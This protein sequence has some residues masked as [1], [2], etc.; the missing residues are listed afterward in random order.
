MSFPSPPGLR[1][2]DARG[3][4]AAAEDDVVVRPGGGNEPTT[5]DKVRA[6]AASELASTLFFLREDLEDALS[7]ATIAVDSSAHSETRALHAHAMAQKGVIEALMGHPDALAT[8]RAADELKVT[9]QPFADGLG[10]QLT[11]RG[12]LLAEHAEVGPASA[13]LALDESGVEQHLEVVADGR[14]RQ[15][16][17]L[18]EVADARLALGLGLDEAEDAEPC[19]VGEHPERA[20]EVLGIVRVE[21]AGQQR[22][23]RR[24]H[25]G[26]R[27]HQTDIDTHR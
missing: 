10:E 12:E 17:R 25:G 19:G 18:G 22:R 21:R 20:G 2:P 23:A 14:L 11:K 13:L 6:E 8:L 24:G 7:A 15:P 1:Q 3:L 26:D 16:E 27:L 4:E 5:D 9:M